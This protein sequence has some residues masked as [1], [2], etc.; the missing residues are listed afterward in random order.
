MHCTR[1]KHKNIL[2]PTSKFLA[3]EIRR[4]ERKPTNGKSS[5]K[6]ANVRTWKCESRDDD[7]ND[8]MGSIFSG[9]S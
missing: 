8:E 3:N 6:R 4:Q 5:V 7:R 1:A 9:C 2:V